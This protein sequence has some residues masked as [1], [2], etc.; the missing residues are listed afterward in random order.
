MVMIPFQV[1][2]DDNHPAQ[3]VQRVQ[4]RLEHPLQLNKNIIL[5]NRRNGQI[6]PK[7]LFSLFS[8]VQVLRSFFFPSLARL[9]SIDTASSKRRRPI[10]FG[11]MNI[12]GTFLTKC[13]SIFTIMMAAT[14]TICLV[15]KSPR[16]LQENHMNEQTGSSPSNCRSVPVK[17]LVIYRLHRY[18]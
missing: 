3:A 17:V 15:C 14:C 2:S 5:F 11:P 12:C 4:R 8:Y 13:Q 6:A 16:Y 7:N 10:N 18:S 9:C 1:W